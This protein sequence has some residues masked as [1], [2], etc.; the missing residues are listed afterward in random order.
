M[1]GQAPRTLHPDP[2]A[3]DALHRDVPG[4]RPLAML[5]LLRFH[6]QAVYPADSDETPCSGRQAYARYRR[7]TLPQLRRVGARPVYRGRVALA[8]IAP[9]DE[10]FDEMFVVRYPDRAAFERMIAAPGYRAGVQHRSAALADSRLLVLVDAV[11]VGRIGWWM[12][13][14]IQRLK[15]SRLSW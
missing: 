2:R 4:D 7:L 13:G 10:H 6:E 5:N 9:E 15:G 11:A 14:W 1:T 3:I 8:F 12:L